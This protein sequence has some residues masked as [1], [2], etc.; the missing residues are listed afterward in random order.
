MK[1]RV[2]SIF[3]VLALLAGYA[4]AVPSV[5]IKGSGLFV[6]ASSQDPSTFVGVFEVTPNSELA[7][8][9]GVNS[10]FKTFCMEYNEPINFNT[11]YQATLN[12]EMV[13]GGGLRPGE[14]AGPCGGD[15]LSAQ[16]AYLFTEY[17]N[18]TLTG[19]QFAGTASQKAQ[20][21]KNLQF[22]FWHLEGVGPSLYTEYA[23]LPQEAK[24]FVDLANG[25]GWND[26]G[27]VRVLNLYSP[28]GAFC[29]DVLVLTQPIP[30]PGSVVLGGIGIG[31]VG[32]LRRRKSL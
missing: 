9:T 16:S 8:M 13:Q 6:S 24:D 27:S 14:L 5:T 32:W 15:L 19:Y 26:I 22:A 2:C 28:T 21:A 1:T 10:P 7:A 31:L 12:V 17:T 4:G 30:E 20:S 25:S 18:Q 29:Q 23:N 3:S 11:T